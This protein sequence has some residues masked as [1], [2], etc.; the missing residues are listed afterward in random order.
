MTEIADFEIRLDPPLAW[1]VFNRPDKLNAFT[2][3][4][5]R[6]LPNVLKELEIDPTVRVIIFRGAGD[7]AFSAGADI[8]ELQHLY[9]EQG[10]ESGF[11]GVTGIA[12]DAIAECHTP[13]IAM[14]HGSC[15]GGG[16]A[17]A[18][19]ADIRIASEEAVFAITPARLGIG[20]PFT[21]VERAVQELGPAN[22]RYMLMTA[23]RIL[24][25]D[26]L[27]MNLIQEIHKK[28]DLEAA[29]IEM[30]H[31]LA[32]NA[33]KSVRAIRKSVKQAV[34]PPSDR[35]NKA[36]HQ[37]SIDCANSDDYREGLKAFMEKRK[38][39]FRGR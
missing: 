15:F 38:P 26:A 23:K 8:E 25:D 7:A 16:C 37:W 28:E 14:I 31:V 36:I 5:W 1:I 30:A 33:P 22:A 20:Y 12:T 35:A 34:L 10:P 2:K 39:K 18:L 21:G 11:L 19:C 24:A 4:M 17:I 6:D 27:D 9:E 29:T 32:E 3:R 13:T